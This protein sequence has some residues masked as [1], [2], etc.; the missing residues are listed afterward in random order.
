[1]GRLARA[2]ERAIRYFPARPQIHLP[3]FTHAQEDLAAFRLFTSQ[4]IVNGSA[5]QGDIRRAFGVPKVAVQ[6]AVDRYRAGGAAAFFVPPQSRV[7]TKLTPEM[8]AK[9]QA[10]L[11]E[12]QSVPQISR[13]TGVLVSRLHPHAVSL[14]THFRQPPPA[15]CAQAHAVITA[16]T[17]VRRGLTRVRA[18]RRRRKLKYRQT[19]LVPGPADTPEKLADQAEFLK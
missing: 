19:G 17:G 11:D 4:L 5:S 9:V 3:V 12:R 8:L 13:A 14:E 18:C 16:H 6:R 15:T 2:R 1:M 10:L 7:G